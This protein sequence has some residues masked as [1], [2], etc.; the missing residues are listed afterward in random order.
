MEKSM[1]NRLIDL[2]LEGETY[3]KVLQEAWN[4]MQELKKLALED[5]GKRLLIGESD[6]VDFDLD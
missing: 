6:D 4:K 3:E 2:M 5:I 1:V